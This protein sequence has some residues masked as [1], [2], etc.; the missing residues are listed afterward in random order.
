MRELSVLEVLEQVDRSTLQSVCD[1]CFSML[2]IK[3]RH[4]A[5]KAIMAKDSKLELSTEDVGKVARLLS[6]FN[7]ALNRKEE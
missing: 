4:E 1:F 2:A 5:I 7:D 3:S 6:A